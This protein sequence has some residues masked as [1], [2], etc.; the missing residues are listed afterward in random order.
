VSP[1]GVHDLG[2]NAAEWVEDRRGNPRE[3]TLRGGGFG[4]IGPCHLLG[5]GCSHIAADKYQKDIGFRCARSVID[6]QPER[7]SR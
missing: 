4:S 6:S 5:S 3:K 2:G 7:R 1:E